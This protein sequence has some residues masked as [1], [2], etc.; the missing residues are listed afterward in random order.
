MRGIGRRQA[1]ID[2]TT[3]LAF[4]ATVGGAYWGA[5]ALSVIWAFYVLVAI[6]LVF[7]ASRWIFPK[8]RRRILVLKEVMRKGHEYDRLFS[9]A[10]ERQAEVEDLRGQIAA[11]TTD[12][13]LRAAQGIL[14][15]R[16]RVVGEIMGQSVVGPLVPVAVAVP[17]EDLIF[18][19][20][21]SGGSAPELDSLV[22]LRVKGL[23]A[24]KAILRVADTPTEDTVLLVVDHARDEVFMRSMKTA[25]ETS[26]D[27]PASLEIAPRK[28]SSIRELQKEN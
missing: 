22:Y 24:I 8:L 4:L 2:F 17:N 16:R 14:A 1:V 19:A 12:A 15:G 13:D 27:F 5:Q 23:D 9:I 25:A 28:F 11:V 7:A 18:A 10:A 26:T 21:Y 3:A 6:A 20:N